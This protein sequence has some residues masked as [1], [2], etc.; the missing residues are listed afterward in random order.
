[1]KKVFLVI[2]MLMR[3]QLADAQTEGKI[4]G[5]FLNYTYS[6]I[7]FRVSELEGEFAKSRNY[8]VKPAKD[9]SFSLIVKNV[10]GPSCIT[11]NV[12]R[13]ESTSLFFSG[14]YDLRITADAVNVPTFKRT[15]AISGKGSGVNSFWLKLNAYRFANA[16]TVNW[17]KEDE[18]TYIK[19]L[20]D[21]IR[22]VSDLIA[23]I[24]ESDKDA[25][26]EYFKQTILNDQKFR[27]AKSLYQYSAVHQYTY[28]QT[29]NLLNKAG[30]PDARK[31]IDMFNGEKFHISQWRPVTEAE[32]KDSKTG[33]VHYG[34]I[35]MQKDKF[36]GAGNH[37]IIS[38]R[39]EAIVRKDVATNPGFGQPIV[40]QGGKR[41]MG[42]VY[43]PDAFRNYRN[44]A[45]PYP[46]TLIIDGKN[47]IEF[48]GEGISENNAG[49][50][51]YRV[52]QNGI[53]DLVSWKRP[54]E[55]RTTTDGKV[56]YA[57]LGKFNYREGQF[58]HLEIKSTKD[59]MLKDE[60]IVDWRQVKPADLDFEINYISSF[61]GRGP[62]PMTTR[63]LFEPVST[64]F[65]PSFIVSGGPD[66]RFRLSD[67]LQNLS[68]SLRNQETY[69]YYVSLK[70][71]TGNLSKVTD[72]GKTNTRM[73]IDRMFWNE[74]GEYEV[75]FTPRLFNMGGSPHKDF[76]AQ[77]QTIRFTVMPALDQPRIFSVREV[78]LILTMF[79]LCA[80]M[81]F[82][83]FR[84]RQQ[85]QL[86]YE[87]QQKELATLQLRSVRSQ[88]NP[89][90][91]FNALAGIQNLM[92]RNEPDAANLYL[93]K[94]A[95]LT[96]SVLDDN[97]KDL[98]TISSEIALLEDYLEMEKMRFGFDYKIEIDKEIDKENTEIPP[99]LLQPFVE[100][101]VKHG[102][103]NLKE[104][105]L[106]T[107]RFHKR[108]KDLILEVQDNA[109]E[110]KITT[111]GKGRGIK[112]SEQRIDLYNRL[113]KET[114]IILQI[115]Q[116]YGT[117]VTLQLQDWI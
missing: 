116:E 66:I 5:R 24:G 12:P 2:Y 49:E 76:K 60:V 21:S 25:N 94:F 33:L 53:N 95:R 48:A 86:S 17:Y 113:H 20:T 42:D 14:G 52:V 74:P 112:L 41:I 107:I 78:I 70:Q 73:I 83:L 72:M 105:G 114:A 3:V 46:S 34:S 117:L 68:F 90:F 19:H 4:S 80:V 40:Q 82:Y 9:G 64:H 37:Q 98:V 100:N 81:I 77:A 31:Y 22:E 10:A 26:K 89:H 75:T 11:F 106:V 92:N 54:T 8:T 58:L 27:S 108:G 15:L 103:A 63:S 67:S 110:K 47:S 39:P 109:S 65:T 56:R 1:M 87:K 62:M 57:Y 59:S 104:K 23:T 51:L 36:Y 61:P 28:Q 111:A 79:F 18:H 71:K 13:I 16:D 32:E 50:F 35:S 96:R 99:M 29:Q 38:A 69:S 6:T 43:I 85:K 101:A 7:T 30:L 115:K 44:T 45:H 97:E 93:S 88:L 55:F 91:M 84:R 102:V